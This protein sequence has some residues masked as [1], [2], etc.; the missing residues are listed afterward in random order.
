MGYSPLGVGEIPVICVCTPTTSISPYL[1][2]FVL[3]SAAAVALGITA[4]APFSG[5][6][7]QNLAIAYFSMF[8]LVLFVCSLY[9]QVFP[10]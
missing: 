10:A 5:A 3:R 9:V 4:S 7:D 8:S 1:S 6:D 2:D